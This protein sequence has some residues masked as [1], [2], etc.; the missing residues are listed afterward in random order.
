MLERTT[1]HAH[2]GV[3]TR[4]TMSAHQTKGAMHVAR[5]EWVPVAP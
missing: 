4:C 1:A 3:G 2:Y 5:A